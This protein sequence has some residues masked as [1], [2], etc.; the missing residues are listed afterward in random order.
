[1]RTHSGR[2]LALAALLGCGRTS[3]APATSTSTTLI[4]SDAVAGPGDAASAPA[5]AAVAPDA[6]QLAP[7][8]PS[9]EP[10]SLD[11][12]LTRAGDHL[13]VT[14][15][16][17]NTST[18]PVFLLDHLLLPDRG[19][20]RDA[21][22]RAVV[23]TGDRAGTIELVRGYAQPDNT[24]TSVEIQYAPAA[25]RLA[26]GA[27]LDGAADIPLPLVAWHPFA[28]SLALAPSPT[29]AVLIIGYL[30]DHDRWASL[31]LADGTTA[32]VPGPPYIGAQRLLRAAPQAIP[33]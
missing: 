19:K 7:P 26:P 27:S 20:W 32:T 6:P 16:V 29:E 31:P 5:D 1:M 33:R 22:D 25:R 3:P 11:W 30:V 23:R 2:C 13:H 12:T 17:H 28:R 10:I 15:T 8:A 21:A 24:G 18:A 14:Y 9:V 4:K